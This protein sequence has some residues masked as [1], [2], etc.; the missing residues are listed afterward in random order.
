[1]LIST[2][3]EKEQEQ[4]KEGEKDGQNEERGRKSGEWTTAK[5]IKENQDKGDE[6]KKG[7]VMRKDDE[8]KRE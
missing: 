8:K 7:K 4:E 5:S 6:R 2:P 1:M 3:Y